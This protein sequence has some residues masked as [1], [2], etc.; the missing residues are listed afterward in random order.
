MKHLLLGF[1]MIAA[2]PFSLWG[3]P[4]PAPAKSTHALSLVFSSNLHGEVEPCG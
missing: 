3:Q 2:F 1:L 4:A